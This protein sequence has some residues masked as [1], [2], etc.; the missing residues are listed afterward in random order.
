[1]Q[2]YEGDGSLGTGG[3]EGMRNLEDINL[4]PCEPSLDT[5]EAVLV[6]LVL[7]AHLRCWSAE[8]TSV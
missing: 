6:Q 5:S 2:V 8:A 1:M 4:L 7:L 3:R